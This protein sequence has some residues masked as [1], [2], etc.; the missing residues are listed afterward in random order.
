MQWI[1]RTLFIILT[2]SHDVLAASIDVS[3]VARSDSE[4]STFPL[5][6]PQ[7]F[8][9]TNSSSSPKGNNGTDDS[10]EWD[11]SAIRRREDDE[12]LSDTEWRFTVDRGTLLWGR[13]QRLLANPPLVDAP[14]C[15]IGDRWDVRERDAWMQSLHEPWNR[16]LPPG[17]VPQ[18]QPRPAFFNVE[19]TA[20][21]ARPDSEDPYSYDSV[22]FEYD[23]AYS[24]TYGIIKATS[25]VGIDTGSISAVGRRAPDRCKF[26]GVA[27]DSLV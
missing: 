14:V 11:P 16:L 1:F 8:T 22:K 6:N 17:V 20:P 15:N 27:F 23:N 12:P 3:L 19:I 5:P 18:P 13:L 7:S 26:I 24:P 21:K 4:C 25:I 9:K 2:C 10:T